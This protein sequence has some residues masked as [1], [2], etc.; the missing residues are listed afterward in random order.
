MRGDSP[1][2]NIIINKMRRLLLTTGILAMTLF[3][4]GCDNSKNDKGMEMT[5]YKNDKKFLDE[6]LELVELKD[7]D[8]MV[9]LTPDYQGRVMTSTASGE[10]GNSYGWINRELISSQ[11]FLPHANNFGGEDR[12]WIGPEGGQFS[13]FF[14]SADNFDFEKWQVPSII[15]TDS[16]ITLSNSDKKATFGT[17]TTFTNAS[18]NKFN[19]RLERDIEL[20]ADTELAEII[21]QEI[22]SECLSI[23]F[24]SKNRVT[25]IG[26][27][28]WTKDSGALSIWI[29]GQF[30][31]SEDNNVI[32]PTTGDNAIVDDYFGKVPSDRLVEKDGIYYFKADGQMRGKIGIPPSSALDMVFA[33]DKVNKVLTVVKYSFDK[34]ATDYVNSLWA[35]Q[36]EPF[37]GDVINSYNDG[38]LEDGTIMGGFYEIETSSKA[39]FLKSG[40]TF[41]HTHTTVHI[42]GELEVLEGLLANMVE[43]LK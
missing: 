26:T 33:L 8:K 30:I 28:E 20:V 16:W 25:N 14:P 31:S 23:G 1:L 9:L 19:T 29:L 15:D 37:K 5:T 39:L 12:M 2:I 4:T 36:E 13:I 3:N 21:G 10:K 11:K 32:I 24:S 34:T 18:G 7:G 38:P 27:N 42:Q 6:Y 35:Y 40:E 22:P 43:N 41:E 17:T